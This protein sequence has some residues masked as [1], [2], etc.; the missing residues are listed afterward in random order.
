LHPLLG[1]SFAVITVT[2]IKTGKSIS[3]PI[4][5]VNVDGILSVISMHERTWWRN[6]R[7]GRTAALRHAGKRF[8]VR[9]EVLETP[10]QIT[11][12]LE[13]YFARYPG[14]MKYFKVP[15]GPDGRPDAEG[16]MRI[17]GERVII[18]LFPV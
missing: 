13:K 10:V 15:C 7:K 17:A 2:G 18:Q 6:L 3:T 14:Y 4:N 1:K 5:V 16:L 12:I 11:R 9:A 8:K